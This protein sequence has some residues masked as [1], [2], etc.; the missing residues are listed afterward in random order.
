[1]S[2]SC[3]RVFEALMMSDETKTLDLLSKRQVFLKMQRY[4]EDL[5]AE[6]TGVQRRSAPYH[7]PEGREMRACVSV[8]RPLC[9][10]LSMKTTTP[11][12]WHPVCSWSFTSKCLCSVLCCLCKKRY[13][14]TRT[15]YLAAKT[16][17][18]VSSLSPYGVFKWKKFKTMA[19]TSGLL[20]QTQC[21]YSHFNLLL[22]SYI[23]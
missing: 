22:H 10:I 1:M 6:I 11:V 16:T 2:S 12:H 4:S 7:F 13:G 21:F 3:D 18:C 19:C 23:I 5:C 14:T 8:T 15:F 17:S 9:S 20:C